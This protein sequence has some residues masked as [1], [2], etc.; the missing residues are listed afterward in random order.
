MNDNVKDL[1]YSEMIEQYS[2]EI[3]LQKTEQ[4][5]DKN[6]QEWFATLG[7]LWHFSTNQTYREQ[8]QYLLR[9]LFMHCYDDIAFFSIEDEATYKSIFEKSIETLERYED[10]NA[11]LVAIVGFLYRDARFGM[12]SMEKTIFYVVKSYERGSQEGV[13]A[14]AIHLFYGL[15]IEKNEEK[16]FDII[17]RY[18]ATNTSDVCIA[19][20]A[21]MLSFQKNY[22][23]AIH[24]FE[25]ITQ[26]THSNLM[27][28]AHFLL[29]EI[30]LE[31]ETEK[32]LF[33]YQKSIETNQVAVAY[34]HLGRHYLYGYDT[35]AIQPEKGIELLQIGF[36]MGNSQAGLILGYYTAYYSSNKNIQ[37]AY[38]IL[39]KSA[40]F[41]N[42]A[43]KYELAILCLYQ[44]IFP[45]SKKQESLAIL[46]TIKEQY[47]QAYLELAYNYATGDFLPLDK[48]KSVELIEAALSKNYD[49]AAQFAASSFENGLFT[50]DNQPNY[51]KALEYLQKGSTMNNQYCIELLG[52]Y[53]RLGLGT[54]PDYDLAI[55]FMQKAIENFQST[56]GLIELAI[57]YEQ[58]LGVE[59][60]A[61]KAFE[62]YQKAAEFND[63]YAHYQVA[64]YHQSGFFTQNEPDYPKA[65]EHFEKS[66]ELGYD[67]AG[68]SVGLYFLN[69]YGVEANIEKGLELLHNQLENQNI[70]A[71]VDIALHYENEEPT[72]W[73][74]VHEYMQKAAEENYGFALCKMG[75]YYYNGMGVEI[76]YNKAKSYYILAVEN[77]YSYA[78]LF[79]G[80]IELWGE[81]EDSNSENAFAYYIEAEKEGYINHGLGICYKYGI[82]TTQN[83]E[84]AIE[85]LQNA[86]EKNYLYAQYELALSYMYGYG[87]KENPVMAL[88]WFERA[89]EYEHTDSYYYAGTLLMEG[90]EVAQD[91]EKG[92]NYITAA[93]ENDNAEAQFTLANMYL[94]GNG[95]DEDSE[96]AIMWF[97]K[98]ADLGHEEALKILGRR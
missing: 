11:D 42:D 1:F 58:G 64:L 37:E 14:Y 77:D 93:A 33:H 46:D 67:Y 82:G 34:L 28:Y 88:Q 19:I 7:N 6:V 89:I 35:I 29:A 52:K 17:D 15:G 27:G 95:V 31:K 12:D 54:A 9:T 62:L 45:T 73:Q 50:E 75:D 92:K 78:N 66:F 76:D 16:A 30:Y 36:E 53:Y 90:N 10:T 81:A 32:A 3:I 18:L 20:K 97:N 71:A 8:T 94:I 79:L 80:N 87:T 44:D 55:S 60:D 43:A 61:Q 13:A 83:K 65:L 51:E 38:E 74:K 91:L 56:F 98:A 49:R 24:L 72:D 39:E 84:I 85:K 96:Q 70:K 26:K 40:T 68:Y 59:E 4:C 5:K 69:G 2:P 63:A 25:Q 48:S 23:V 57:C 86:A 47:P 21:A 41:P 22:E